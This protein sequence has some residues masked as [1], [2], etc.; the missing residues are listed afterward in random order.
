M[1]PA[2]T[3]AT[4]RTANPRSQHTGMDPPPDPPPGAGPTTT[5]TMHRAKLWTLHAAAAINAAPAAEP[6]PGSGS[7]PPPSAPVP[8]VSAGPVVPSPTRTTIAPVT[9]AA[10]AANGVIPPNTPTTAAAARHLA[11][12]QLLTRDWLHRVIPLG[13]TNALLILG[14]RVAHVTVRRS[15]VVPA[16]APPIPMSVS[17]A[18]VAMIA[19][20]ETASTTTT[21]DTDAPPADRILGT[22]TQ[23]LRPGH[24]V[25]ATVAVKPSNL[26][27]KYAT[28]AA[29]LGIALAPTKYEIEVV[30]SRIVHSGP[31]RPLP[32]PPGVVVELPAA[33]TDSARASR[34]RLRPHALV[35]TG[36]GEN[37][38]GLAP[39]SPTAAAFGPPPPRLR[40]EPVV[41]DDDDKG[42]IPPPPRK[43]SK[44]R[45]DTSHDATALADPVPPPPVPPLLP[46]PVP[47]LLPP[48]PPP[49]R[50]RSRPTPLSTSAANNTPLSPTDSLGAEPPSPPGA[51]ASLHGNSSTLPRAQT[52]PPPPSL[53]PT[54]APSS[55]DAPEPRMGRII[56][57]VPTPRRRRRRRP[58]GWWPRVTENLSAWCHDTLRVVAV[59]R[60]VLETPVPLD[61]PHW[62]DHDEDET[63]TR[64]DA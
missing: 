29:Q 42:P 47:P 38:P 58:T 48:P 41:D 20:A 56:E 12:V 37:V 60:R 27:A 54:P 52:W 7:A 21:D 18:I 49:T 3:L 30:V 31:P 59:I 10:A 46:P 51:T 22:H 55:D 9:P 11:R 61:V 2:T 5:T 13:F 8:R 39:P 32:L 62:S 6:G 40:L 64:D 23:P 33:P 50:R 25:A 19:H 16:A 14:A 36:S 26:S 28:R 34:K 17:G 35:R 15:G 45:H 43:R 1:P 53:L 63:Q 4:A 57:R 44:H 24:T